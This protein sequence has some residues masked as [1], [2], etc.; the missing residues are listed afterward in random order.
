MHEIDIVY[1]II[2]LTWSIHY[3]PIL[4]EIPPGLLQHVLTVLVFWSWV[5]LLPRLPP[6][7]RSLRLFPWASVLLYGPLDIDWIC[8]PQ[9]PHHPCKNGTHSTC[10]YSTGGHMSLFRA[11]F[12]L[13]RMRRRTFRCDRENPKTEGLSFYLPNPKRDPPRTFEMKRLTRNALSEPPSITRSRHSTSSLSVPLRPKPRAGQFSWPWYWQKPIL[14]PFSG[15]NLFS[16]K[17]PA[18][19]LTQHKTGTKKAHVSSAY[20][21]KKGQFSKQNMPL[22]CLITLTP[23]WVYIGTRKQKGIKM[24]TFNQFCHWRREHPPNFPSSHPMLSHIHVCVCARVHAP[25]FLKL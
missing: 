14:N 1:Q 2:V 24:P 12:W 6:W 4:R 9:L 23:L 3:V 18:A 8:C 20:H 5:L 21:S 13:K 7:S 22:W 19:V 10:F 25:C 15:N 11:D 16:R 17:G